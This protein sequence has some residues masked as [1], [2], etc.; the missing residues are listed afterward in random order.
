M[1]HIRKIFISGLIAIIPISITLVLIFWFVSKADSLLRYPITS[2]L[3]T[4]IPGAGFMALI[5]GIFIIGLLANNV[6]GRW[7][8]KQVDRMFTHVPLIR[9]IYSSILQIMQMFRNSSG[10]SFLKVV[11][12]S[13]PTSDT[14]SIGFITNENVTIRGE[15]KSS[16]FVP[17]TPN[18]SNGFLLIV[19]EDA[20]E[21]LDIPVDQAL[22]MIVSMGTLIPDQFII[23]EEG[24]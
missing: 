24:E 21:V 3:G 12:L 15:R 13:F 14:Q 16:V 8:I 9:T 5:I 20:Y 4:Y 18:P 11:I 2:L 6:L 7:V 17:T 22:K 1:K 23:H 19:P 10:K